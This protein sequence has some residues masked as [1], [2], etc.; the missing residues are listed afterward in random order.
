MAN[1]RTR[2]RGAAASLLSP[3]VQRI[4]EQ[5]AEASAKL[6][7]ETWS[8]PPLPTEPPPLPEGAKLGFDDVPEEAAV[9]APIDVAELE[10]LEDSEQVIDPVTGQE[11]TN[12]GVTT[13]GKDPELAARIALAE[14]QAGKIAA[15][16]ERSPG[17]PVNRVE[18]SEHQRLQ[19][20]Y[21]Q[22]IATLPREV[23]VEAAVALTEPQQ[24][25]EDRQAQAA[26]RCK[27]DYEA[28]VAA[29]SPA[30]PK[31]FVGYRPPRPKVCG[32]TLGIG[33]VV[34]GAHYFPR[35]ESWVNTGILVKA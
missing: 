22:H 18:L 32:H 26:A 16:T 30:E 3:T 7:G 1:Q 35:I 11:A 28:R 17:V 21:R 12:L 6:D 15:P 24:T 29:M 13:G 34:P 31:Y 9:A 5:E 2:T 8:L 20:A 23:P 27:A 14:S 10:A 25:P 33:D 4:V 19:R